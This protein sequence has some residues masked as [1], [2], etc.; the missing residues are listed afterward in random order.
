[1]CAKRSGEGVH[2]CIRTHVQGHVS[3]KVLCD[4]VSQLSPVMLRQWVN[5][6]KSDICIKSEKLPGHRLEPSEDAKL[7][8]LEKRMVENRGVKIFSIKACQ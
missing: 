8:C 3:V 4:T 6:T 5:G 7:F 1:M 2:A